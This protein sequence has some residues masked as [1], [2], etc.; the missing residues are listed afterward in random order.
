MAAMKLTIA[1][2]LLFCS[3]G[4]FAD[5]FDAFS[6][7]EAQNEVDAASEAKDVDPWV[8]F[9]RPIFEF[10]EKLDRALLKP[11]AQTYATYVPKPVD[12]GIT[13]VFRNLGEPMVIANDILQLKIWQAASD[14]ARFVVNT[15]LGIFGLFDVATYFGLSRH[16]EDF[17]QT[18]GYWGVE[19]GPYLMLP[20]LGPSSV[21]DGFGQ[22]VH[23]STV[24]YAP[25]LDPLF[26]LLYPESHIAYY[27]AFALRTI[28][29]RASLLAVEGLV[30]GDR[31]IFLRSAYLQRREYLV[32]DGVQDDP[33]GN[34]EELE[35]EQKPST[36]K[37]GAESQA[38]QDAFD[39]F[40]EFD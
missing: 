23:F 39:Q 17:G 33:F 25:Q 1:L 35:F 15:T 2:L 14:S 12:L 28:D 40:S 8:G 4:L 29:T 9:N 21:R 34:E 11:V 13:N 27:A 26:A 5:D 22:A 30:T 18:L 31:Y 7:F 16:E 38:E 37:K 20:F 3:C 10:N 19:S 24:Y 36:S 6:E 32:N